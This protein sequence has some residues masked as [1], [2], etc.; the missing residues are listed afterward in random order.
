[1]RI[2]TS[3]LIFE[4]LWEP[5]A[6]QGSAA[7]VTRGHLRILLDETPAWGA[8]SPGF[9][10]TWI[11]LLE[12][13]ARGWRHLEWEELDPLGLG[14]PPERIRV[15]AGARWE[16][17]PDSRRN[18]E[19][20]AL[21]LFEERHN[22]SAAI[23][24]A[25]LPDLWVLRCG[26]EFRIA[27]RDQVIWEPAR[28]VIETLEKLGGAI[29]ERLGSCHDARANEARRLWS[30]RR[31]LGA[32][33]FVAITTSLPAGDLE[34][35]SRG[36]EARAFW[37]IGDRFEPNEILAAA[38]MAGPLLAP[39]EMRVLLDKI[40]HVRARPSRQLD[41]ITAAVP[42]LL[43]GKPFDQGHRLAEWLRERMEFG[44][45]PVDPEAVLRAWRIEVREIDL[46]SAALDA[47]CCWGDRHGP[48]I[49]IN[50]RG[51]HAQ[52]PQGRRSTLAH[53]ICHLIL[54]RRKALPLAE[55][56]G[57]RV[58]RPVEARA[59]AF[60]AEFLL[61]RHIAGAAIASSADPAAEVERLARRFRVS[62]EIVAWQARNSD[63]PLSAQQAAFLQGLV[64]EPWRF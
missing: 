24:G 11:E 20:E 55:V 18:D 9:S 35:I 26:N 56:L 33:D 21:W 14:S 40:R 45:S 43:E 12:H 17:S 25:F 16:E 39:A 37:E 3:G 10:W 47:V 57:G 42:A 1:M 38:R 5:S 23:Q 53:E 52:R 31:E 32:S 60:A 8:K 36:R 22:L 41:E 29:V 6:P 34:E 63:T 2:G 44:T 62:R 19:E 54:D 7:E 46:S 49:L 51:R 28:E 61:P 27:S 4:L 30:S 50:T 59:K 13:L 15:D 64:S 48:A 58:S